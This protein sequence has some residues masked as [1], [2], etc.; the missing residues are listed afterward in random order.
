MKALLYRLESGDNISLENNSDIFFGNGDTCS[1]VQGLPDSNINKLFGTILPEGV[2]P[3]IQNQTDFDLSPQ[4]IAGNKVF[5]VPSNSLGGRLWLLPF[6]DNY[7]NTNNYLYCVSVAIDRYVPTPTPTPTVTITPT[8]TPTNTPPVTPTIS[9]TPSITPSVS[10]TI[11]LTPTITNT[12]SITP[13][14]SVTPTPT[15][16]P[17]STLENCNTIH[18]NLSLY[19]TEMSVANEAA[20]ALYVADGYHGVKVL[21]IS[22]LSV[23]SVVKYIF[24]NQNISKIA[25]SDSRERL[26][27]A[28]G[29]TISVY[30]ISDP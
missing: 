16:T 29:K 18:A 1:N 3:T 9:V 2:D 26:Y 27:I 22:N 21:D 25:L 23:P 4:S 24:I 13:T 7:N 17:T 12:P 28:N 10:P 11:S 14:S 15:I 19:D 6:S 5:T 30:N 8:L 20:T